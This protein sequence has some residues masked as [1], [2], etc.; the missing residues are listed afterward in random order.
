MRRDREGRSAWPMTRLLLVEKGAR[1]AASG[2]GS[3]GEAETNASAKG[4]LDQGFRVGGGLGAPK[5]A[6]GEAGG[7]AVWLDHGGDFPSKDER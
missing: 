4:G 5:E 3:D 2:G 7:D 6:V 1:R